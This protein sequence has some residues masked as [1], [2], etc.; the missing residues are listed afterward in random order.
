MV[1]AQ[2]GCCAICG[3]VPRRLVVDHCHSTNMVRAL[4]CDRC[5]RGIGSFEDN[6]ELLRAAA[7]YV[8]KYAS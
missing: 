5:N 8:D 1:I 4:L 2:N 3:T 6:G 7:A